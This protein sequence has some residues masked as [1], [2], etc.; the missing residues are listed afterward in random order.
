MTA[1]SVLMFCVRKLGGN[2][3]CPPSTKFKRSS[4]A[5]RPNGPSRQQAVRR[6]KVAAKLVFFGRADAA[7]TSGLFRA[8]SNPR[9]MLHQ[10][11][12][13]CRLIIGQTQTRAPH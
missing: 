6:D 10:L 2:M 12:L 8:R 4:A 1:P 3:R 7:R 5:Q 13:A 9:I 11:R